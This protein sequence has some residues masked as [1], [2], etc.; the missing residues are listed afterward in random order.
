MTHRT[1]RQPQRAAVTVTLLWLAVAATAFQA[2]P[3]DARQA[4][5]D[6]TFSRDIKPILQ[7]SCQQCHRPDS[8]APMSLVTYD[9]VRP[10]AAAIR[11]ETSRRTMP[12][13]FVEKDVGIQRFRN[14]PSL[15]DD[16]IAMIATWASNGA[17]RGNPADLP[18]PVAFPDARAWT[19]GT[20]DLVV[21]SPPVT[22]EANA[23]DWWGAIGLV[24][25]GLTE[26]RYVAAVETIE[27]SE[28]AGSAIFHH[29][30]LQAITPDG[31]FE[32]GSIHE[33][34]RNAQFYH[35]D[36]TPRLLAGSSISFNNAH[37]HAVGKRTTARLLVG[38][39]FMP[40][41]HT[42]RYVQREITLG[43][44]ELDVR[45]NTSDQRF[46]AFVTLQD[47]AK[48]VGFEPHMHAAGVRMCL[49]AVWGAVRQTLS[50]V[51]FDPE[52]VR[53]YTYE[54][55]FA[56]LLP[57]GTILRLIGWLDT[58]ENTD[59][60]YLTD[61][62]NWTGW[63]SRPVDNMF[64]NYLKVVWLTPRQLQELVSVRMGASVGDAQHLFGCLPCSL[65]FALDPGGGR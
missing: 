16:E 49:E 8:I 54:P 15:S 21:A 46:E 27:V 43:T 42:P 19:L 20:P 59:N 35:E 53:S 55:T 25:S 58:T 41:G 40:R 7:R 17:P 9:Q 44:A 63:G 18:P 56:P 36:A 65:P 62:R 31:K 13:W 26:D 33:V 1:P 34:G 57:K 52:W 60:P 48:L 32:M 14:D 12:P 28:H 2:E 11:R 6:V 61:Y 10:W 37:V 51:G 4:P 38:F 64:M 3:V 30:G 45:G 50:C 39:T 5:G 23:T 22:V 29:A 47:A 24:P